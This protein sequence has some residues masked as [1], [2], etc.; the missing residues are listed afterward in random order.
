MRFK[1]QVVFI[2][3]GAKGL[4][5]AMTASF[6]AEGA[7][8][9]VNGRNQEAI[10][11]FEEEF[12]GKP[13]LSFTADVADYDEMERVAAKV[14]DQWGK[15]DILINNAG[16]VNPLTPSE[17][18]KKGDFD[19]VIDI[20]LKGTFYATQI[21]GKRMIEKKEGRIINIASQVALF[22]EKGFLPYAISKSA[23][24][25]MARS[26]AYEWS[27][28]GVTICAL[29]PGF[30]KGGMNEGLIRKEIFVDFLSKKTP[31]GRMGTVE[32]FVSCVLFLA[33]KDA[34]YINGET[35]TM[36][37]GMTGYTPECLLDFISKGK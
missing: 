23:L 10:A 16:V 1:D 34:R 37:G 13:V 21:F 32:E 35:I 30:I 36:D 17:K 18:L 4:G 24:M 19:K 22:G 15:V 25:M 2:T 7:S 6:L 31:I 27:R 28:H 20:N 26:L 12:Q 9:A 5:K 3:G 33:S 8:V 14:I 11:R 29:A